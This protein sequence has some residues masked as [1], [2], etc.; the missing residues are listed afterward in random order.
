MNDSFYKTPEEAA[1]ARH[2]IGIEE[3]ALKKFLDGDMSGYRELWS[4]NSFTYFDAVTKERVED[5]RE[6]DG[7]LDR[8]E[9]NLKT[10]DYKFVNPRVQSCG[11][12]AVLTYQLFAHTNRNDIRYNCIEVFQKEDDVKW[13]VIH[14]TWSTIRPMEVDW[15]KFGEPKDVV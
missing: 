13:H 11:D 14:S 8:L 6:M 3:D 7:F 2:I 10:Y 5:V 4:R 12:M 9:G 15:S 1:L